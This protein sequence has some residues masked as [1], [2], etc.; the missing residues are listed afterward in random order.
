MKMRFKR[1]S[2]LTKVILLV[3]VAY[4]IVTLVSL[5]TQVT[6]KNAEAEALQ[7]QIET[8]R[9]E[10]LRIQHSID[11]L[12]TEEGIVDAAHKKLGWASKKE[13]VFYDMGN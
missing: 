10:N 2:P 4:A 7:T 6:E 8:A 1:S 3:L 13:I 11:T 9:Q 12:G 5:Q